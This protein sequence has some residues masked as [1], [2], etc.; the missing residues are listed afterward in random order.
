MNE[1]LT[2]WPH[3]KK[4][5]VSEA[6]AFDL[7]KHRLQTY[8]KNSRRRTHNIPEILSRQ[9]KRKGNEDTPIPTKKSCWL[10]GVP[11]YLPI[12]PEG[13]NENTMTNHSQRLQKEAKITEEMRNNTLIKT[14]MD[15]TFAD[16]RKMIVKDIV[17][18]NVVIEKYP[19]LCIEEE[20]LIL[21]FY[22]L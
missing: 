4:E 14:L 12:F 5:F 19:L 8:F 11:N 20:V 16:R 9:R 13:K 7:W 22:L 18:V 1:I 6:D 10:L 17:K 2:K 15:L 3:L 21:K